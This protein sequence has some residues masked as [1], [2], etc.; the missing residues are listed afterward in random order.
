MIMEELELTKPYI[1]LG[2]FLQV[3]GYAQSGAEAKFVV[4]E[5]AI[6]V[7]GDPENRRGRKLYATDVVS[8][9]DKKW[10]LIDG[11]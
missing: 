5:L 11:D 3:V 6:L 1:T 8:L 2:Q 4:K 10:M 9:A 7:N